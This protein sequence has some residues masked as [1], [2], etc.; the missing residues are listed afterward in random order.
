[1]T[2]TS[3]WNYQNNPLGAHPVSVY[4]ASVPLEH[5]KTVSSVT[6]PILTGAG[7]TTAMHIFAIATGNGT[8]TMGAPYSS[9]ADAYDN[10]GISDNSDPSAAN[11]DG[12][13]ESYSAQALAAGSPT[14]LTARWAGDDRR[15][16][17][18]LAE[19]RSARPTT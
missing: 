5:G 13:G 10:A 11:F 15:Y 14:P 9:I 19:P 3:S 6:L 8:P 1:M 18:H 16:D 7:G 4:F 17:V 12:T 2:T